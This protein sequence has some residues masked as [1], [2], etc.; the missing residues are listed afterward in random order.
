MISLKTW[1]NGNG[2]QVQKLNF[3][4]LN[5]LLSSFYFFVSCEW[6]AAEKNFIF[7][8]SLVIKQVHEVR[9][10]LASD[11]TIVYLWRITGI[12]MIKQTIACFLVTKTRSDWK[13]NWNRKIKKFGS[14]A[15]LM[16]SQPIIVLVRIFTSE[17][18][19]RER[20]W[21]NRTQ[22][23]WFHIFFQ[24]PCFSMNFFSFSRFANCVNDTFCC[25]DKENHCVDKNLSLSAIS[26]KALQP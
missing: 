5:E 23:L 3:K 8:V 14:C 11:E 19:Q 10:V 7:N 15:V 13:K 25:V 6:C 2:F 26:W 1:I 17:I 4:S 12:E 22:L 18:L 21:F 24:F 9:N 20:N 16:F